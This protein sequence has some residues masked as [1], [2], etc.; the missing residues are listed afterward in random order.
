ME[1][2]DRDV[3]FHVSKRGRGRRGFQRR[4]EERREVAEVIGH[5]RRVKRFCFF[6]RVSK[7]RCQTLKT[8][9]ADQLFMSIL[10]KTSRSQK[11]SQ[12][13]KDSTNKKTQPLARV[14]TPGVRLGCRFEGRGVG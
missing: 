1:T 2:Q 7:T 13:R 9:S 5:K 14:A 12:L 6:L 3:S 10:R 11:R 4:A 8:S